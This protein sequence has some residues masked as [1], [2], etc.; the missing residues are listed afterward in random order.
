MRLEVLVRE[1]KKLENMG[2][3]LAVADGLA[4]QVAG[5]FLPFSSSHLKSVNFW[6]CWFLAK[7]RKLAEGAI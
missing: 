3:W 4:K 7:S 2:Q 5:A 6:F 1:T